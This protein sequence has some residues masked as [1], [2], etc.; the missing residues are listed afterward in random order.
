M[1]ELLR[2]CFQG[3]LYMPASLSTMMGLG[4]KKN[5]SFFVIAVFFDSVFFCGL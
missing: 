2:L 5:K 1:A 4:R 3:R